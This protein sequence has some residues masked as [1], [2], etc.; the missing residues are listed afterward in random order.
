MPPSPFY[1]AGS[2]VL[3]A[4]LLFFPVSKLVW[5][6]SVRRLERKTE[7]KLSEQEVQGQLR[8]ARILAALLVFIFSFLFSVSLI[9][10][11]GNG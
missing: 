4:L 8:R 10:V 2:V 3:L 9:G 1:F 6:L 7:R 11:P 5:V